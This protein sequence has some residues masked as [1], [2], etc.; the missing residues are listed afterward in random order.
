MSVAQLPLFGRSLQELRQHCMGWYVVPLCYAAL[1][2]E[3]EARSIYFAV[4][5]FF[6]GDREA[7]GALHRIPDPLARHDSMRNAS[8]VTSRESEDQGCEMK[9]PDPLAR[10]DSMRNASS[11]TSR[12]SEDQGCAIAQPYLAHRFVL[13][14]D[15]RPRWPH[16]LCA[17]SNP[18]LDGRSDRAVAAAHEELFGAPSADIGARSK[19]LLAWSAFCKPDHRPDE[20]PAQ[21]FSPVLSMARREPNANEYVRGPFAA[22]I[23]VCATVWQPEL[24]HGALVAST[25][26][27]EPKL[28]AQMGPSEL[29]RLAA[30]SRTLPP[31]VGWPD[32]LATDHARLTELCERLARGPL[33]E[34]DRAYLRGQMVNYLRATA[35]SMLD[36]G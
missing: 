5:R 16:A 26:P 9:L 3:P 29:A 24:E 11:V 12:E 31:S 27:T 1:A 34:A 32:A 17:S 18:L 2:H 7:E 21:A 4:A 35:A 10:H 20:H 14:T 33:T 15:E 19:G 30:A 36:D 6:D 13:S 23:T 25:I 22:D 28:P 8:S